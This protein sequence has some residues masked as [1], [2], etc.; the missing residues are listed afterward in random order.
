VREAIDE[1]YGDIRVA[2][3]EAMQGIVGIWKDRK[4]I[5]DSNNYI[6]RLR[7]GRSRM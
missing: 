6:R 2:R 3:R 7:T 4:D 5:G 1:K